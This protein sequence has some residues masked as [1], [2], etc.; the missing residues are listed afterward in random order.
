[1]LNLKP[2]I[3]SQIHFLKFFQIFHS[4][5]LQQKNVQKVSS[6][7]L[8]VYVVICVFFLHYCS[9]LFWVLSDLNQKTIPIFLA[10]GF[11]ICESKIFFFGVL[12]IVVCDLH[13]IRILPLCWCL[14]FCA[15]CASHFGELGKWVQWALVFIVYGLLYG[16]CLCW[17]LECKLFSFVEKHFEA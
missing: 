9:K 15:P 16:G 7:S 11:A 13:F 17:A 2:R 12:M 8:C 6:L 1:M 4:L 3:D 5:F 10:V 14:H